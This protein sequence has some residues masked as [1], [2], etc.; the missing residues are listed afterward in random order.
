M[1]YSIH[2]SNGTRV[3]ATRKLAYE[4]TMMGDVYVSCDI[5]SPS[6]IDWQ[7]GDYIVFNGQ[8]FVMTV[9]PTATRN[10]RDNSRGDAVQYKAVRFQIEAI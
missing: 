8:R 1:Q 5:D 6:P 2:H 10:A 9:L 3:A 4:G 7:I